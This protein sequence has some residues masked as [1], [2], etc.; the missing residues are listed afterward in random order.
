MDPK[1]SVSTMALTKLGDDELSA[2]SGASGHAY[3]HL[4]G[5]PGVPGISVNASPVTVVQTGV[6]VGVQI[7]IGNLGPVDQSLTQGNLNSATVV[8][9]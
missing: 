9:A 5:V 8:V 1:H 4:S 2:V 3:G 6:N 7:A